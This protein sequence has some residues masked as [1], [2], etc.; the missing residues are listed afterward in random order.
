MADSK[1]VKNGKVMDAG[2]VAEKGYQGFLRGD[3]IIIPGRLNRIRV[4]MPRL[5]PRKLMTRMI[6]SMQDLEKE[7]LYRS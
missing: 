3:T 6:R 7:L 1:M 5:L 2:A 4:L